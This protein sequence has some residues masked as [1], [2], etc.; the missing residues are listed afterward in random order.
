MCMLTFFRPGVMPHMGR[1]EN[2]TT[3]N[4][5]GHGFA[6]IVGDRIETGYSMNA[7]AALEAFEKVRKLHPESYAIF[8]S[9]YTTDGVT[10]IDNCHPFVVGG[11]TRTVLAHNGI[12]P[13]PARPLKGDPRSDTAILADDLIPS[14]V[15]GHLRSKRARRRLARWMTPPGAGSY[16]NKVA[17]LTVDPAYPKNAYLINAQLGIEKDGVWYSNSGYCSWRDRWGTGAGYTYRPSA[18][19]SGYAR[20]L[21]GEIT[22]DQWADE[23]GVGVGDPWRPVSGS[24]DGDC[25][26]C[27]KEG[28][29]NTVVGYCRACL[30]CTEC[31]QQTVACDCYVP[32]SASSDRWSDWRDDDGDDGYAG[33]RA[34]T[35]AANAALERLAEEEEEYYV[36][37]EPDVEI[38][39][40]ASTNG[41]VERVAARISGGKRV[42]TLDALFSAPDDTRPERGKPLP[43]PTP[44]QI[45]FDN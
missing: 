10:N 32:R 21:S 40:V 24:A 42:R 41:A 2:G 36:A 34:A 30:H 1:L 43:R 14:G 18:S 33:A 6:V 16:P 44:R 3:A 9:R 5:D 38:I 7:A 35:E 29:V 13:D 4:R 39:N 11:D 26:H 31:G 12:L 23:E 45:G 19:A 27:L 20:W 25:P 15:F 17:I 37:S 22:W 28:T 8:H